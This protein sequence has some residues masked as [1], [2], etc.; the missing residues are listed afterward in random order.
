MRPRSHPGSSGV[1][2]AKGMAAASVFFRP[3]IDILTSYFRTIEQARG[4]R[5]FVFMQMAKYRL[6]E[7][8]G[9]SFPHIFCTGRDMCCTVPAFAGAASA[10]NGKAALTVTETM[11]PGRVA[12]YG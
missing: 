4:R 9:T 3:C 8:S 10:H 6:D 5:L 1:K 11:K 12:F 7:I 2:L